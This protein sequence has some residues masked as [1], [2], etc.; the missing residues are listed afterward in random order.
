MVGYW[1]VAKAGWMAASWGE[2]SADWW[3]V[4][5]AESSAAW[6][7]VHSAGLT[8]DSKADWMVDQKGRS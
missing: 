4:S 6:T 8:A 1:V 5:M 7:V 2:K 3:A